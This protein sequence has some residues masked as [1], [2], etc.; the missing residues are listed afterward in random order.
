MNL[1]T[2]L[3]LTFEKLATLRCAMWEFKQRQ[4][5]LKGGL[6]GTMHMTGDDLLSLNLAFSVPPSYRFRYLRRHVKASRMRDDWNLRTK[7]K[8]C[9]VVDFLN[10]VHH[11]TGSDRVCYIDTRTLNGVYFHFLISRIWAIRSDEAIVL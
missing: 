10:Y 2:I 1:L 3:W 8:I 6:S 11:Q 5:F 7:W 4:I 9:I